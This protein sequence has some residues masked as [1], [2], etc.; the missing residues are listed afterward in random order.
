M[1][2]DKA[3]HFLLSNQNKYSL[4]HGD[5]PLGSKQGGFISSWQPS[6]L[7]FPPPCLCSETQFHRWT[8][9]YPRHSTGTRKNKQPRQ[10]WIR[11]MWIWKGRQKFLPPFLTRKQT[12]KETEI[13]SQDNHESRRRGI[14]APF[15]STARQWCRETQTL[16]L[17]HSRDLMI[18]A[19]VH[20]LEEKTQD[21]PFLSQHNNTPGMMWPA[22]VC[23]WLALLG[24]ARYPQTASSRHH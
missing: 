10:A 7:Y 4:F 21:K 16:S 1:L 18:T 17:V 12:P 23:W 11:N 2:E 9:P 3:A 5:R 6:L 20:P 14:H 19:H 15:L 22:P 13:H 24:P 8:H